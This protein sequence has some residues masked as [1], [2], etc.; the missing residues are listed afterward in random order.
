MGG[1]PTDSVSTSMLPMPCAEGLREVGAVPAQ[2]E[3]PDVRRV[4]AD[5]GML[6][7]RWIFEKA[8]D[9]FAV[10]DDVG[11][12]DGVEQWRAGWL[13]PA[14]AAKKVA[15]KRRAVISYGQRMAQRVAVTGVFKADPRPRHPRP[16]VVPRHQLDTVDRAM[17]DG[18]DLPPAAM[19]WGLVDA[20]RTPAPHP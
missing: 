18:F 1:N 12:A 6:P 17:A 15:G 20:S 3:E 19:M 4:L 10:I 5:C 11:N 14:E 16:A 7:C 2:R 8:P 13:E 9:E